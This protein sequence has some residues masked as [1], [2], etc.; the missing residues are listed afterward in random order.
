M[1]EQAA[2]LPASDSQRARIFFTNS[3]ADLQVLGRYPAGFCLFRLFVFSAH[4]QPGRN[5]KLSARR[6]PPA[7]PRGPVQVSGAGRR[8]ERRGHFRRARHLAGSAL[9]SEADARAM[10]AR[11]PASKR[12]TCMARELS[13]FS[14]FGIFRQ[15]P[16]LKTRLRKSVLKFFPPACPARPRRCAQYRF[17]AFRDLPASVSVHKLSSRR[18]GRRPRG[19]LSHRGIA[20]QRVDDFF[21]QRD[22]ARGT[23][24]LIIRLRSIL[25]RGEAE[26]VSSPTYPTQADYRT[27]TGQRG[28][29]W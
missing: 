21:L 25:I 9:L 2:S 13:I 28:T 11:T 8:P 18:F 4:S 22:R 10:A 29:K 19:T 6:A 3:G 24:S 15:Q 1:V 14:G 5:R 23:S 12:A 26:G 17:H 20:F 27:K 16:T 7:P